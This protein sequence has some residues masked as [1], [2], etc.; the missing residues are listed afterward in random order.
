MPNSDK[1]IGI[2]YWSVIALQCYIYFFCTMKWDSYMYTYIPSFLD[3]TSTTLHPTPSRS[4]QGT[5]LSF[6]QAVYIVEMWM[7]LESF[8]QIEVTQKKKNKYC[9]LT[10][11][12]GL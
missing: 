12:C 7:N 6:P 9:I 10:D 8:I 2:F 5:E 3:L 4:S 11:V 1:S